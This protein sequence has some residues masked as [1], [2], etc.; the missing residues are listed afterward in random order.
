MNIEHLL[1][2]SIFKKYYPL[3][4]KNEEILNDIQKEILAAAG[5]RFAHYGFGKTTMA[6]IAKDCEMSAANLY[7]FF[8]S[9][10]GIAA[11]L[12]KEH[13]KETDIKLQKIAEL[14]DVSAGEKIKLFAVALAN[15]VCHLFEENPKIMELVDYISN[16]R[17]DLVEE[18]IGNQLYHI[19]TILDEGVA[20]GEFEIKDTATTARLLHLSLSSITFPPL[21]KKTQEGGGTGPVKLEDVAEGLA[22]LILNG[23]RKNKR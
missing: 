13:F 4:G 21:A 22:E 18:K 5:K 7:R 20:G 15:N 11:E 6:E 19:V 23:L 10:N 17:R 12:A 2:C 3:M 9:K 8:D 16:E 14:T 1:D